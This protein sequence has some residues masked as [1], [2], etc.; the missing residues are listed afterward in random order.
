MG[1]KGKIQAKYMSFQGM[2]LMQQFFFSE[3][4]EKHSPRTKQNYLRRFF[5][6]GSRVSA[7]IEAIEDL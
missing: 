5:W 6:L 3:Q 2:D 4:M 1:K 7:I